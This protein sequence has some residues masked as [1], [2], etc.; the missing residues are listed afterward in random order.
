MPEKEFE[1]NPQD[2]WDEEDHP[3]PGPEA[4]AVDEKGTPINTSSLYVTL[5]TAEV[6]LPN[7]ESENLARVIRRSVDKDGNFI[8]NY[9]EDP[10]LNTVIYDVEFQ[11]GV[12]KPYSANVIAQNI[13]DQVDNDGCPN[14]M[15]DSISDYSKDGIAVAKENQWLTSKRGNCVQKKTTIGWKSLFKWKYG[16]KSCIALKLAK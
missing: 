9:N 6:V 8:G 14:Q 7:G 13:L 11:D 4:D 1:P 15:L 12:I 2:A 16:S 3:I 5:I 10:I